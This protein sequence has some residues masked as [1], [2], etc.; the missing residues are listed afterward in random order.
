YGQ[1]V[2]AITPRPTP[3]VCD[4]WESLGVEVIPYDPTFLFA[5]GNDTASD[6]PL[7]MPGPQVSE[8][9]PWR[10]LEYYHEGDEDLFFGRASDLRELIPKIESH[11][12]TFLTG[13][14]GV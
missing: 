13:R 12:T 10:G 11:R 8:Q 2:Y 3:F 14:S 9:R 4:V 6:Q 1:D 5:L 7:L